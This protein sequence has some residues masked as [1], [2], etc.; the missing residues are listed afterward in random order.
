MKYKFRLLAAALFCASAALAQQA[1][2]ADKP[3]PVE[4]TKTAEE[5]VVAL[6]MVTVTANR[7]EQF[8][9]KV[10]GVVQTLDAD[11]LRR[12]G[13]SDIRL[14]Q[15]AIPG[16]NI[17]NQEGNVEI[18]IRGVGSSN[19]TELGDP[20]A[21]PHF[22]GNYIARPRGLGLM[23]YD[24]ERVEVN[25]GP[26]GTI[27][28]RNAMA[29]TLN[30]ISAKPKLGQFS[31]FAQAEASNRGGAGAEAAV[32]MP[33]GKDLAI[34][35]AGYYT[36]KDAGYTNA[37]T[38][39]NAAK[40]P[41]AGL[42]ENSAARVSLLWEP[43]DALRLSV[44]ADT[45]KER[46]TGYPGSSIYNAVTAT[47]KRAD[48]LDLS[49]VI[50]RGAP[51]RLDN[52]LSGIQGKLEVDLG[53]ISAE[54][55]V[56]QRKVD[57]NQRNAQADG[58]AYPGRDQ[59]GQAWDVYSTQY[60]LTQSTAKTVEARFSSNDKGPLHWNA[61]AFHFNENQGVGYLSLVDAGYCCY[62]G[63]EFTMPEVKGRSTAYFADA[64]FDLSKELR[65]IGGA[66]HTTESKSRYGIGGNIALTLGAE[67]YDCCFATR[68]G[69]E[70][71]VPNL[72]DRPT[73]DL[74]KVTTPAQIAQFLLE[75]TKTPGARD[76]VAAQIGP[77]ASGANPAGGCFTR[78]DINNG[79]K[80]C[81]QINPSDKKGG[82]SY[83]NLTI[84]SQ[85]IGASKFN[86][87]DF[88]IGVEKDLNRDQ[89]L[90][91]KVSTGH[92]A[93]GFNDSFNGSNIPETFMPERLTVYEVGSRNAFDVGGRRAI[94]NVTGFYYDYKDQVFQDLTCINLDTSK[95][96]PECAGY[97]LVNRNI[98]TSRIMG[99]ELEGKFALPAAFN[100]DL[101]A[102]LLDTKIT[103]GQ[104]ADA[105]AIDY[106]A[107]GKS[108]LVSLV[109]NQLPLASRYN[110]SARLQQ[111]F[112]LGQGRFDWQ[113]LA[114]Y[115]SSYFLT[116]FNET[117]IVFLDGSRLT[118]M[119]AGFPDSQ[120]GF[121]TLNLGVGYSLAS[122]R[123][124]AFAANVTNEQ[125]SM[126]AIIGPNLNIRFLN[127]ARSYGARLRVNF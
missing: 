108:P 5:G 6:D 57:F 124:E 27:Y 55:N 9:Q 114:N 97:S 36:K 34:R 67:N 26:Q 75:T 102:T 66:R 31:G 24:L 99:L 89:M 8:Q 41:P 37:S 64:T 126:K 72:L 19:N 23:F 86:Y 52:K 112:A 122:F 113:A 16:L 71:F 56:A 68:F 53:P 21:A 118:A 116:Q 80:T 11:Q 87:N 60:W 38:D 94:F 1:P 59:S 104:V 95:T 4:A 107:G 58:I 15:A 79:N 17:A 32:N 44:V 88:R 10:S 70:G 29:G 69:T 119:K 91:A 125:A 76:T 96:P 110:L 47:G 93:G 40:L 74:S 35:V 111:S 101:Q 33:L 85:Q 90:Y 45:G 7:R 100:L 2:P 25:K 103:R 49:R 105:R 14:L 30:I 78:A 51:G 61:G 13:I 54:F 63:T 46:G 109:G 127:D 12:D 84:P 22:N 121:A 42:E 106:G 28:G 115:R 39:A 123:V 43:T 83:A 3:K 117:D 77:I 82:F 98:G 62:S 20:A 92:K 65:L 120:R 73:F 18:Y 81:P 50:Y 48:E